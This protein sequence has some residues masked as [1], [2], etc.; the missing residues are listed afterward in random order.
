MAPRHVHKRM[1]TSAIVPERN[2]L[3]IMNLQ[4]PAVCT[5]LARPLHYIT[6]AASRKTGGLHVQELHPI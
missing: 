5:T 4:T 3:E 6:S 1:V 2:P